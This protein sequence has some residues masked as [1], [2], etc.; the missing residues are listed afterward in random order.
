MTP[1]V[2]LS[3][4]HHYW[5]RGSYPAPNVDP[6]FGKWKPRPGPLNASNARDLLEYLYAHAL[7]PSMITFGN[8]AANSLLPNISASDFRWVRTQRM[9]KVEL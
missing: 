4:H 2:D 3:Y 7:E 9:N 5:H 8:E 1:L 6:R